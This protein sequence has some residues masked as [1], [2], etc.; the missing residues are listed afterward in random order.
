MCVDT[1]LSKRKQSKG[2]LRRLRRHNYISGMMSARLT[3]VQHAE[4]E[5]PKAKSRRKENTDRQ[6]QGDETNARSEMKVV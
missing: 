4:E 5:G 3:D 6:E 2:R 1:P